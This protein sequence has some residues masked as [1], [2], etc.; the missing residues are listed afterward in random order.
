MNK[1]L[2]IVAAILVAAGAFFFFSQNKTS[3]VTPTKEEASE[4]TITLT[5]AG[6]SPD[7]V[8]IKAGQKITWINK[9][10]T[11]A[12]V[13][14]DPHPSHTNF[15]PLNLGSFADGASLS[16]TFDQTGTYGYHNHL[17]PNARGTITVQ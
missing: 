2:L 13:N 5:S 7:N 17:N 14:S 1:T 8:T 10:G 12:T 6:F 11:E 15:Q 3:Q 9:S 16:L 4:P